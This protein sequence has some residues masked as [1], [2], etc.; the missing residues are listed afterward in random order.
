MLLSYSGHS[1]DDG[2]GVC[3]MDTD[4]CGKSWQL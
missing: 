1:G 2:E 4:F 3:M